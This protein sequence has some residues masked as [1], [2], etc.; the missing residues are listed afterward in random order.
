MD[1]RAINP[2]LMVA[3]E[4]MP[5]M[6]AK[7]AQIITVPRARPPRILPIQ[8]YTISYR[9]SPMPLNLSMFAMKTNK[10][11]ANKRKLVDSAYAELNRRRSP[12]EPQVKIIPMVEILQRLNAMGTPKQSSNIRELKTM[13]INTQVSI[14]LDI[15]FSRGL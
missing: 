1:G 11:I 12:L 9:S 5:A 15:L 4:L 10:G 2:I 8:R 3:T 7:M 6:A 14:N 13:I